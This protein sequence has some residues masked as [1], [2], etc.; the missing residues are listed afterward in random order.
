MSAG[1]EELERRVAGL[2]ARGLGLDRVLWRRGTDSVGHGR[3]HGAEDHVGAPGSRIED[4]DNDTFVD[5]E[6]TAD[7]DRISLSAGGI[8]AALSLEAANILTVRDQLALPTSAAPAATANFVRLYAG[9]V[10]RQSVLIGGLAFDFAA[11]GPA[12]LLSDKGQLG[13]WSAGLDA[14]DGAWGMARPVTITGTPTFDTSSN[15]RG[16]TFPTGAVAS[17]KAGIELQALPMERDAALGVLMKFSLNQTTDVRFF[18]GLTDQT[19][20]TMAGADNPAGSY[21]GLRYSTPA[22]ETQW[23]WVNKDGTTQRN[24]SSGINVDTNVHYLRISSTGTAFLAV[25]Y[26]ANL[27]LIDNQLFG[28]NPPAAGTN[29]GFVCGLETQVATS[30]DITG[31]HYTI[32]NNK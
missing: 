18:C 6:L 27:V 22:A 28:L 17:N 7:L 8:A 24:S 29:L 21:L 20:A 15:G 9:E 30:K 3:R 31:F 19:L 11:G 2:E 26:D 16:A 14:T 25:L 13:G 10:L 1:L 23:R 5:T 12:G 32:F 4:A